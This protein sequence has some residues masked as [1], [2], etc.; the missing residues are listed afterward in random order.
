VLQ[1]GNW[2]FLKKLK[3]VIEETLNDNDIRNR[4]CWQL[5]QVGNW[6]SWRNWGK[7]LKRHGMTITSEMMLA[8]A[9]GKKIKRLW[10]NWKNSLKKP[11]ATMAS[12]MVLESDAGNKLK[13]FEKTEGSDWRDMEWQWNQKKRVLASV[14][15][16]KLKGLKK[17]KEVIQKTWNDNDVANGAGRYCR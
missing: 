17:L 5:L 6:K 7:W 10:R 3:E 16:R 15:V 11:R 12:E 8:S 13:G 2:K 9:A 4:E 14:A 1:V